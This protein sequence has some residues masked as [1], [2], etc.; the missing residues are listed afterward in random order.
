[1]IGSLAFEKTEKSQI[2]FSTVSSIDDICIENTFRLR[3]IHRYKLNCK[4]EY[5]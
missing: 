1:M 3:K 5:F 2:H 4:I